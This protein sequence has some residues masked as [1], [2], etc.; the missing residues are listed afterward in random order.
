MVETV[1]YEE[2]PNIVLQENLNFCPDYSCLIYVVLLTL[3]DY[4]AGLKSLCWKNLW[5][6]IL[7]GSPK[8][9]IS[10]VVNSMQ[11]AENQ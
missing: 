5:W 8:C 11:L 10:T 2:I 9:K 7:L 4:N 1:I 6:E 3:Y